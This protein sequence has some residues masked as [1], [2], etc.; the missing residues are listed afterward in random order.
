VANP[1]ICPMGIPLVSTNE[2]NYHI[3]KRNKFFFFFS[4][5]F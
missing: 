3:W 4:P 5:F 1:A 2:L